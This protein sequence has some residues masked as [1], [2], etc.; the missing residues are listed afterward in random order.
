[1]MRPNAVLLA[2]LLAMPSA[3][4]DKTEPRPGGDDGPSSNGETKPAKP[5]R[6]EVPTLVEIPEMEPIGSQPGYLEGGLLYASFRVGETQAFWDSLPKPDDLAR[7]GEEARREIG[8]NPFS[9]KWGEHFHVAP[10]AI[11]SATILRPIDEDV[12]KLLAHLEGMSATSPKSPTREIKEIA[13]SLGYHTRI[14]IPSTDPART[15]EAFH[16]MFSDSDR[17]RGGSACRTLEVASCAASSGGELAVFRDEEG[18]TVVDFVF[19][20]AGNYQLEELGLPS[21]SDGSLSV[22]KRKAIVDACLGHKPAKIAYADEL[23]GDA[24]V[25]ID[26]S[27]LLRLAVIDRLDWAMGA[28]SYEGMGAITEQL[29]RLERFEGLAEATRLFPG[30]GISFDATDGNLY[31]VA[32]WPVAGALVGRLAARSIATRASSVPVPK[33]DA[34]CDGAMGCFRMQGLPDLRP[35]NKR[36][37]TG[38][39]AKNIEEVFEAFDRDE[40]Y[41][42]TLL[43]AG[44]WPN[45]LAAAVNAPESLEGAEAGIARTVRDAV[46]RAD[47]FGGRLDTWAVRGFL[48]FHGSG[49]LYARTA[50]QDVDAAKGLLGLAGASV[51]DVELPD[52]KGRATLLQEDGVHFYFKSDDEDFG[53]AAV[54][55]SASDFSKLLSMESETPAGPMAY[56]EVPSVWGILEPIDEAELAFLREWGRGRRLQFA[57]E[58]DAGQPRLTAALVKSK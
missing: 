27:M 50:K 31:G 13:A 46:L 10:D 54:T 24:A 47:G 22:G 58:L 42:F 21:P 41:S 1:M 51:K 49:V 48:N 17:E 40:E 33:V 34:L 35:V 6:V 26:P 55:S 23:A 28:V 57:L 36:L 56:L 53:W 4:K 19:F 18:A 37:L 2:A 7:E 5:K 52:G 38:T 15:R 3:C 25:W 30:V 44:A 20:A 39:F 43:L 29:E 32:N 16:R 9:E 11:V 45:L 14:H 8:F 12:A